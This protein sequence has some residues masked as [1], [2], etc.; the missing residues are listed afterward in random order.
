MTNIAINNCIVLVDL[1]FQMVIFHNNV[2]VCELDEWL[3]AVN[4]LSVFFAWRC[5]QLG[6]L[7]FSN[8]SENC[9]LVILKLLWG[10]ARNL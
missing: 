10:R 2:N 6:S 3:L 9:E 4:I 8:V 7:L 1:P 5:N